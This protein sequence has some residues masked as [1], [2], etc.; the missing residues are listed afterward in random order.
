M[1]LTVA[2]PGPR[3]SGHRGGCRRARR[4]PPTTPLPPSTARSAS[5]RQYVKWRGDDTFPWTDHDSPSPSLSEAWSRPPGRVASARRASDGRQV[6]AVDV[7]QAR[8]GPHR[9]VRRAGRGRVGQVVVQRVEHVGV[10]AVGAQHLDEGGRD[11]RTPDPQAGGLERGGVAPGPAADLE[12]PRPARQ[13]R[14]E[15]T[16]GRG[17]GVGQVGRPVAVLRSGVV[18][19]PNRRGR[20]AVAHVVQ[21]VDDVVEVV[22]AEGLDGELT[23]VRPDPPPVPRQRRHRRVEVGHGIG[24]SHQG[25]PDDRRQ[26]AAVVTLDGGLVLVPVREVRGVLGQHRRHPLVEDLVDVV[27]VARVLQGRPVVGA[28]CARPPLGRPAARARPA[29]SPGRRSR[30][31]RA[32]PRARRDRTPRTAGRAPRSSPWCRARGPPAVRSSG[33][34]RKPSRR[35]AVRPATRC[36]R[37]PGTTPAGPGSPAAPGR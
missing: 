27:H 29:R 11:V 10:V 35:P 2:S 5:S 30:G 34:P 21:M 14:G 3:A 31:R 32:R 36:G 9:V 19:G 26:L 1:C 37:S 15:T 23:P 17:D 18:V 4:A 16:D 25:R 20:G 8:A 12:D 24:G 33:H 6:V 13:H 28:P 7:Q 22:A